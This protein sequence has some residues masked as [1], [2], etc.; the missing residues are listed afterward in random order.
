MDKIDFVNS[1]QPALNDTNLNLMQDNI[2]RAI[3]AQV[4]GDTL[5]I[6]VVL[7]FS[8]TNIP[9]NWLLCDGS[10]ISR[11][12]YS[13]LFAIIGVTYG[14][15]DGSTT[16]NLPDFKGKVPV[17]IDGTQ[18]EFNTLAKTGG[19]KTH[20]L[21]VNEMPSHN[22][23]FHANLVFA[24]SGSDGAGLKQ[25]SDARSSDTIGNKGGGQ[26]HNNLQPYIVQKYIIKAFQTAGTVAQILNNFSTSTTDGYSCSYLNNTTEYS[27]T[28][29]VIGTWID[30]K[31]NIQTCY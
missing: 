19:E 18:T 25:G 8:G 9:E 1:T 2:E 31:T 22:H 6:G 14:V 15:G 21:T 12:T 16:F 7:P 23:T 11:T 17:G 4:S 20:T 24:G 29:K 26:A 28:E 5:P 10:A 3:N 27:T 13:Q 30:R